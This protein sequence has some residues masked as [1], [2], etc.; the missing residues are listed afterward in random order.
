MPGYL[1]DKLGCEIPS[2]VWLIAPADDERPHHR[3]P[4]PYEQRHAGNGFDVD[5]E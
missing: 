4:G 3:K 1:V 5:P 2:V